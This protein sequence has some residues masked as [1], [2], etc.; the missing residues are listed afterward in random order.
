MRLIITSQEDVASMNIRKHLLDGWDW[1]AVGTFE[2]NPVFEHGGFLMATI[3]EIHLDRDDVDKELEAHTGKNFEVVVFASRHKA[4]SKIP[5]L[6]VHP[7]GN[8]S[9][10]EFG[11]R[12]G[13]LVPSSPHLMTDS[14]R[15]IK[16]LSTELD[17]MVSFEVTHH[18]PFLET[19]SYFIEIGS[20]ITFWDHG[21][22]ADVIAKAIMEARETKGEVVTCAGGGHYAPRFTDLALGSPVS[23]SHMAANYALD[24]L[25]DERIM[26]EMIEKSGNPRLVYFHRKSMPKKKYRELKEKFAG[27]GV[28]AVRSHDIG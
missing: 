21:E 6:T 26:G 19:P 2:D 9:V 3:P 14:L 5:T 1:R 22:A 15:K 28:E 17:F 25:Y 18:G 8:Y 13:K 10:A 24:S 27:F 4:E 12:D 11:G 7:I 20:D 16:E 23:I